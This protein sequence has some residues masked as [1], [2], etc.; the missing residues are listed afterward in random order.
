MTTL[1]TSIQRLVALR[2][3][4]FS[5]SL[6]RGVID[7]DGGLSTFSSENGAFLTQAPVGETGSF[8][9]DPIGSGIKSTQQL[10]VDWSL[11]ENHVF[12]NS[13]QVKVN[14]AFNKIFDRYPFDGT[15]KE[16]ELFY[17]QMTGYEN[18]VFTNLP[19]HKGYLFFS[20]SNIGD[21]PVRGTWITVK[22]SAGTSFPFLTKNPNGASRL[23]P[24]SGSV[25]F[26]FQIYA[27]SGSNSNQMVFQK[28]ET[29]SATEQHGFGCFLSSSTAP[30][31]SLTFFVASGSTN[32]M[33][34]TVELVKESWTPITFTW[35][36]T[37]GINQLFGYVSGSLV[38]TSSQVT[39]RNLNF[40]TASLL[41]G[42]GSNIL[43][44]LFTPATTF[45]GAIDEF[46]YFK[47]VVS[48]DEMISY[49]S[50]SIY[51]EPELAL[52]FKFN[53]PSGSTTNLVLDSSGKGMHGTL[54]GYALNI[55]KVRDI[56]TG[57]YMGE[58]PMIYEDIR[59]CPIL[60]PDQ[61]EVVTYRENLISDGASY[62]SYNPN[63]ITKLVP[64]QYFT[65]GQEQAALETEEGEINELQYGSEPNTAALGST[66]TLLSLLYLWA[67]FF[68]EIK[69]FLDA[70]STLRHVD[71]DQNDTAPDAFLKQLADFYGLDLPP[72]FIGSDVNQFINGTNVTPTIVNSEYTLQY[73]QNQIW[74]RILINANDILKSKGTIHSIKAFL[75]AVGIDGDNIFRFKEYGG[76]TQRTLDS[77]RESR[78]EIGTTLNFKAGGYVKTPYLSGSRVE[79]GYPTPVGSFVVDPNTGHNIGTTNVNDGLFT[80]GSWTYEGIYN[81][82][83][84]PSTSS[85]QSLVRI[86]ST[87]SSNV[88]NVLAN[89]YA[90]TGSGV[91]LYVKPNSTVGATALT[92]SITTPDIMNGQA[93]NISFGRVRGDSINQVS[94]SYFLRVGRNNLGSIVEEYTTSSYYDD[95]FGSNSANNMWQVINGTYNGSGSFLAFGSGSTTIATT[96]RFVNEHP[97]QTFDGKITQMRWWSEGLTLDEWRE[98]VRDYKSLGVQDP[99]VNFNFENF[100]SGSFQKLRG[101]WNTDQI[102]LMTDS[103]GSIQIFDFSQHY[104]HASGT[105]FP[106]TSSV[107]IP[108][109]FYY[110]FI[111]PNFDEAVTDQKVRVRS[112]QS[113][114]YVDQDVGSYSQA[115]PIYEIQQE[116]IPEDNAKFSIDFSIVDSLNQDMIGMFSSLD[117][118]NNI[119]GAPDMMFSPDYPDLESLRD[120][121]FNR[122]TTQLNIRGFFEF[123][124]WFNTNMGK[125]IEQLLP[126]KT[127]FKGIN[128][129]IQSHMLERPKLEY[130]F[131]DIYVGVNNRNRQKEVLL[132]QL[133]TGTLKKY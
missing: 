60:F 75:R 40:P 61:P 111:S 14:A 105:G 25:S 41:I 76:P 74:R 13:A 43:A 102:E 112:Y 63:I 84:T 96:N 104:L 52:Y 45:S 7:P 3:G 48:T 58:S 31:A 78:N 77:L 94:S 117:I 23:D 50:S 4:V 70:F 27:A 90:T 107:I 122:L 16:T 120:I 114:D 37:S 33:S 56:N 119:L 123:Y 53:E 79:P 103:T 118:F 20:G 71:Y 91:T 73:L 24:T 83:G 10:N 116:Q 108:E 126:R 64:K 39:I 133:F 127:K 132:L 55:L 57:S 54:N 69:L 106:V 66:Q 88:E 67:G 113:L 47:R 110:S 93:W 21:T 19:K 131:E 59:K 82:S 80:S 101:D 86:M 130:H 87:G 89:L 44:P 12:F 97:L 85:V 8:R 129:V 42:T 68:D 6:V 128:Y 35:N 32:V 98:H 29:L 51:A 95:N 28:L 15:Q 22:D 26:Q 92:M 38:A 30:T 46:R 81:Y 2:P 49:Q 17:D 115:A 121:Y 99:L 72:L 34:A 1:P 62:D 18:Y 9:Y 5:P 36:R 100:R 11:F 65:Y 125:F 109:R 124:Q